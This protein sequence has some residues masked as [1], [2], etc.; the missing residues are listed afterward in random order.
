MNTTNHQ[1]AK[2]ARLSRFQRQ[3]RG[4]VLL[5]T[6]LS[7]LLMV[8]Y[9]QVPDVLGLALLVDNAAP[10]FGLAVPLLLLLAL[11]SRSRTALVFILLPTI[12]W[13][14][15]FG[16]QIVPL[17]WS[18]PAKTT[19]SLT[20]SSQNIRAGSGGAVASAQALASQGS[21]VITLQELEAGG[22]TQVTRV[23]QRTHPHHFVVG[24]IGVWSK[25]PL[26]KS[27]PLDLGLG[28]KRALTTEVNTKSGNIRL[29]AVHA[30]SARANDHSNRDEMLGQLASILR[31]DQSSQVIAL[32]DFNA[33]ST[34]RSFIPLTETL[35]EPNQNHGMFGF[36]WPRTPFGFMRL[37]H[38]L[39]RGLEVTSN[40]VV[41][42][43]DSDHL[44][45]LTSLNIP[46]SSS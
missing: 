35:D 23:L 24:T 6:L 30:A 44:A 33:T 42:A 43:G 5:G 16:A 21:D 12:T 19:N 31:K 9:H 45:V 41:P 22:A 37:D 29:Y 18:A 46:A 28:W 39:Q 13:G 27:Q 8:F 4:L 7:T 36:T 25:Y 17:S 10:W 15:S 40:T 32:G 3:L 34:D 26:T 14:M 2:P 1:R 11:F 20:V 38:V